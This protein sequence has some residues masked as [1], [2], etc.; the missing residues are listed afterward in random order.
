M[1][2]LK[3]TYDGYRT[4]TVDVA[5]TGA[6][7]EKDIRLQ[8]YVVGGEAGSY[9][10]NTSSWDL[11]GESDSD[12]TLNLQDRASG[13]PIYFSDVFSDTVV[14]QVTMT[15]ITNQLISQPYYKTQSNAN[16]E[17]ENDPGMGICVR[18][19]GGSSYYMAY[20]TGYRIRWNNGSYNDMRLNTSCTAEAHSLRYAGNSVKMTLMRYKSQF[21]VYL[22]YEGDEGYDDLVFAEENSRIQNA[23]AAYGFA[24]DSSAILTVRY[25]DYSIKSDNEA[26]DIIFNKL[27]SEIDYDPS[28]L[29]IGGLTD[30]NGKKYGLYNSELTIRAKGLGSKEIGK[31]TVNGEEAFYLTAGNNSLTYK[32]T[33]YDAEKMPAYTFTYVTEAGQS[34]SG[35]VNVKAKITAVDEAR[36]VHMYCDTDS[37]GNYSLSLPKGEYDIIAQADGYMGGS[38]PV[39][40]NGAVSAPNI[41]LKPELLGSRATLNG[42]NILSRTSAYR[43]DFNEERLKHSI[44]VDNTGNGGAIYFKETAENVAI[45]FS[46]VNN[47][48]TEPDPGIGIWT[49]SCNEPALNGPSLR[50]LFKAQS[51][52]LLW[53]RTS[54]SDDRGW[55][56]K[57]KDPVNCG[58]W[59]AGY[60]LRKDKGIVY[61]AVFVRYENTYYLFIK[62]HGEE[63][64][65]ISVK[66]HTDLIGGAAAYGFAITAGNSATIDVE[67]FDHEF[68][69]EKSEVK[70]KLNGLLGENGQATVVNLT[71]YALPKKFRGEDSAL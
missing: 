20:H 64:Y 38:V 34:V 18:S 32:L 55:A 57:D 27:Y 60:D 14:I 44:R 33:Q 43:Y 10:S 53:R 67:F 59:Q 2:T 69:S 68:V 12:V 51:T 13:G 66:Y 35:K 1:Y 61:D 25:S 9:K 23:K 54:A 62:Q 22:N 16:G 71:E 4:T 39:S 48:G 47:G 37:S 41:T 15:N 49:T 24:F 6:N 45:A 65:K 56:T 40:V 70:T 17:Y 50:T 31:V 29:E 21:F 46:F 3:V 28:K 58:Q 30:Y 42:T 19:G 26:A 8:N 7:A 63:N 36:T 52:D 11:S 5:V